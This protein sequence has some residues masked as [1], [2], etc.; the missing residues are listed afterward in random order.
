MN[1]IKILTELNRLH[2]NL[3]VLEIKSWKEVRVKDEFG[4]LAVQLKPLLQGSKPTI[5]SA[6]DKTEYFKNKLKRLQPNITLLSDYKGS[7]SKVIVR[8]KYG[9][10]EP[11]ATSLLK[12]KPLSIDIA[13]DKTNYWINQAKEKHGDKYDYSKV[14]FK[15]SSQKVTISCRKHGDFEQDASTHLK[16]Y[17]CRKCSNSEKSGGWYNNHKN[18]TKTASF[19]VI[20]LQSVDEDFFKFGITNNINKRISELNRQC[21]GKYK[22]T[23]I[24]LITKTVQHC[25]KIESRFRYHIDKTK[26]NYIPKIS[27]NGKHEC[28]LSK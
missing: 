7:F 17:G 23:L 13:L 5:A 2:P 18:L 19:Y 12:G 1:K 28:F 3:E 4:E 21:K 26:N 9:D 8:T 27:F 22:I 6:V 14:Q 11:I 25:L 24:K 20:R 10:C 16:G 15:N